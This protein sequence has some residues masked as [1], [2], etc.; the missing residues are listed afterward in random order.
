ME[1]KNTKELIKELYQY[2]GEVTP[3][4]E[5]RF[6]EV[7]QDLTPREEEVIKLRY[8]LD[9]NHPRTLLELSEHF[10]VT[11]ELIRQTEEKAIHKLQH[12]NRRNK[13]LG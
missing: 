6:M 13:V 4:I 5:S 11:R 3:E 9:D 8:G 10:H 7:L 12:P 1:A 2:D